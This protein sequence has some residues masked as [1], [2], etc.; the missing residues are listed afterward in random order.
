MTT[1]LQIIAISIPLVVMPMCIGGHA[2]RHATAPTA[3]AIE[4]QISR[5]ETISNETADLCFDI[6]ISTQSPMR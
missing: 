3:D 4:A 5:I 2:D 1:T 6:W